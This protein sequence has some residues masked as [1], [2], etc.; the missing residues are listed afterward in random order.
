L[1]VSEKWKKKY[2]Y[3]ISL[4]ISAFFKLNFNYGKMLSF[5]AGKEGNMLLPVRRKIDQIKIPNIGGK[6]ILRPFSS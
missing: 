6:Y 3:F 1:P 4:C 5:R 2:F